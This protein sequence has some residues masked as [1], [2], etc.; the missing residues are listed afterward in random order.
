MR[1]CDREENALSRIK[2]CERKRRFAI[3]NFT[4]HDDIG[5][6]AQDAAECL[7]K[8]HAG[9]FG[10]LHLI[11]QF[12]LVFDWIFDRHNVPLDALDQLNCRVQRGGFR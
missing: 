1:D 9:F 4:H 10:D 3:A 7:R 8:R 11:D 2:K 5:V 6:L 12:E